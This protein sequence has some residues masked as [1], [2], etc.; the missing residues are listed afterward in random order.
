VE[1]AAD[2]SAG[3]IYAMTTDMSASP[4]SGVP[5][6]VGALPA[7]QWLVAESVGWPLSGSAHAVPVRQTVTIAAATLRHRLTEMFM[8]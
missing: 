6:R 5:V 1:A 2:S 4:W 3:W 7:A 8:N